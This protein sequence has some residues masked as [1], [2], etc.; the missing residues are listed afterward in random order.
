MET[1][2]L[3]EV[4]VLLVYAHDGFETSLAAVGAQ[5]AVLAPRLV[6]AVVLDAGGRSH[7]LAVR[8]GVLS[9]A[10][11]RFP[12]SAVVLHLKTRQPFLNL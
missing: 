2:E 8:G 5:R 11:V 3:L 1:E 4:V 9:V 10:L 7:V 12:D 6:A